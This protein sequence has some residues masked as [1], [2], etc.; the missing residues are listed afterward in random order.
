LTGTI[1]DP[2]TQDSF[3]LL[4]DWGE[5]SSQTYNLA[6]GATSFDVTHAYADNPGPHPSAGGTYAV[7]V[8]VTDS[9]GS[10]VAGSA[11]VTVNNVAPPLTDFSAA[12]INEGGTT[13]LTG[14]IADPGA[15]DSFTLVVNWGDGSSQ[16]YN[17]A[18]GTASFDVT[19]SYADNPDPHPSSGGTYVIGVTVTDSDGGTGAASAAVTVNNA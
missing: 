6:A 17:F 3:T 18:A 9:D 15:L 14:T 8:T 12:S 1:A 5:G 16:T 11:A 10:T 7:S 2:G 19:H 13:H 4:V